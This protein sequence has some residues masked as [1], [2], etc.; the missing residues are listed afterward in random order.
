MTRQ[1][2]P[3]KSQEEPVTV[4]EKSVTRKEEPGTS[5][6]EP[7]TSLVTYGPQDRAWPLEKPPGI[8]RYCTRCDLATTRKGRCTVQYYTHIYCTV[9]GGKAVPEKQ[10]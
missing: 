1:E 7:A 9:L 4:Q 6:E 5:Q 8:P 2:E 3:G 10:N